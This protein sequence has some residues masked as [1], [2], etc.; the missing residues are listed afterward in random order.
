MTLISREIKCD[1]FKSLSMD[2][3]KVLKILLLS[4]VDLFNLH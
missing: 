1:K 4:G 2:L 3:C